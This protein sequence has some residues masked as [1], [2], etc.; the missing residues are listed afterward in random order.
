MPCF[1]TIAMKSSGVKR[2]IADLQKCSFSERKFEFAAFRFVKLH[3]P[4]P[5]I[6]ISGGGRCNFT[7]RNAAN[8]NFLSENEHFCKSAIARFTPDDFIAMVEKHGIAYHEKKL[9]QLFCDESSRQVIDMLLRECAE[10]KVEIIPDCD[11]ES[12]SREKSFT[13]KSNNQTFE[14]ESLVIATGGLSIP[15]LGATSFG[16]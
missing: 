16:Y 9:G 10:A 3:L 7:N 2:A 12:V 4:P 11:I 8:S 13:V 1:S 15:Q 5:E 6:R 14:T